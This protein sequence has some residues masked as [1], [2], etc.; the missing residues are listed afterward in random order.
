MSDGRINRFGGDHSRQ[1]LNVVKSYLDGWA[2]VMS[3]QPFHR[4]YIDAF[5]G[6]GHFEPKAEGELDDQSY[7][8][9]PEDEEGGRIF[10]EG[11]ALQALEVEPPFDRIDLIELKSSAAE[12]LGE[13]V[14][15]YN[16]SNLTVHAEDAN[17]II[18]QLCSRFGAKDRAVIFLDP[19]GAQV[20][21]KTLEAISQT[22]AADVWY[23]LPVSIINRMLARNPDR[24]TEGWA[25]AITRCVGTEEWRDRFY[26]TEIKT[27]LFGQIPETAKEGSLIEERASFWN[28]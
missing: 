8:L 12:L 4:R 14:R 18:P 1:K 24:I 7:L 15:E 2:K 11:S 17:I 22:Q 27:D 25:N 16:H 19:Y 5:S 21:W 6:T 3:R 10:L 28:A 13:S 23:L 9:E 26:R 20:E